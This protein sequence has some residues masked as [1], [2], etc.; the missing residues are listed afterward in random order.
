MPYED[1]SKGINEMVIEL[2]PGMNRFYPNLDVDSFQEVYLPVYGKNGDT[3]RNIN[4]F[5]KETLDKLTEIMETIA[6]LII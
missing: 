3:M 4:L 5:C 1:R 6:R 2:K